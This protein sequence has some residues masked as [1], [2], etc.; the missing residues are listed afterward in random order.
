ML[1]GK[2]MLKN[3][4]KIYEDEI[5]T[6]V[7]E[8]MQNYNFARFPVLDRDEM[9]VGILKRKYLEM[10]S[11]DSDVTVKDIMRRVSDEEVIREFEEA[12]T[13]FNRA[14]E[15]FFVVDEKGRFKSI[16]RKRH[17]MKMYFERLE[18]TESNLRGVIEC[19]DTAVFSVNRLGRIVFINNF[20]RELLGIN[21]DK[22]EGMVIGELI[23][24]VDIMEGIDSG[25]D[26]FNRNFD[27]NGRRLVLSRYV[28]RSD[29]KAIGAICS[30]RDITRYNEI[31]DELALEKT[32][33]EVLKSV[34]NTAYDGLIVVDA[35]GY[36]TMISDAYKSFLGVE[37]ENV[38]GR[39]VTEIIENTRLH[40][41]AETGVPEV[42]DLQKIKGDYIVASR[43]PVFKNGKVAS[44]VGKIMFRNI[45]EFEK[46]YK[47][48][49]KIEQQLE[50]YKDEL[51]KINKAKYNFGDIVGRSNEMKRA[52]NLAKKAAYTNSNVLILGESGTGKELF[53]HSIH[54]SSARRNKPFIKVNCAAIP[55]D[56]MES[57]LFG[58][59]QGAFTGAKKGGRIGKFEVADQ[60]TIFLDEIGDMPMHMQAKLLRVIQER[61]VERIGSNKTIKI[62][63]RIIAATN[64]N[65]E[66]LIE[67]KRFR[68]DLYYRLNVVTIEIPSLRERIDDI[69]LL[70]R[71][72]LEKYRVRYYKKVDS[73]S[74]SAIA[75]LKKYPWPGNVR[76][77]ENIVERAINIL[78]TETVIKPKHLPSDVSGVF[79]I[80][81][82]K[83][84][85]DVLNETEIRTIVQCLEVVSF[86]KSRAARLL[87]VSR[88]AFYEKLDKYK[89]KV[90]N[91]T[92]HIGD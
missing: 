36:I 4:I 32:E 41:V 44:V 9:P 79:D 35:K 28:A 10:E 88:A 52:V 92:I 12:Y 25:V 56:L 65:I 67:E 2:L 29:G 15:M 68:M 89:I 87:G 3:P 53:A 84:L 19:V 1:V 39:H 73:I 14:G 91:K 76:E 24:D 90:V 59:E 54:N 38:V 64:R 27:F 58:Y 81:D 74:E 18:Y 75:K 34:F 71:D 30:L 55:D 50:N 37:N 69:D 26:E 72:F 6:Q 47:K 83:P 61:E 16:L 43:I 11:G 13:I 46:L 48:I 80:E 5:V 57:E 17:V 22:I 86:N 63:V 45:D 78:D 70:C 60:G 8:R 20:A 51:S 82:V 33:K 40:K 49:G 42:A 85:K 66:R 7:A 21:G 31:T 62:D 23:P 77:L